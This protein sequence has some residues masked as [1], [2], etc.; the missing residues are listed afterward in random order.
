LKDIGTIKGVCYIYGKI[1]GKRFAFLRMVCRVEVVE[2]VEG[3]YQIIHT[4]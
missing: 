1:W 2:V 4:E 3:E